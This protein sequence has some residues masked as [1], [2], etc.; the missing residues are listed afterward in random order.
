MKEN[1]DSFAYFW[2]GG[3]FSSSEIT[4]ML[5]MTPTETREKGGEIPRRPGVM[6]KES[7][8]QVHSSLPRDEVF[9]DSHLS[10][11]MDILEPKK[12]IIEKI[13]E[14]FETGINCVGFY[15]FV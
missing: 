9:M 11:L 4:E 14:R 1:R 12:E 5:N 13:Q 8:W 3:D 6:W 2:V 7:C 10:N 15:T